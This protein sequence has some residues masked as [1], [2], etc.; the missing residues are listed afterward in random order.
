M[1][2]VVCYVDGFAIAQDALSLFLYLLSHLI[3]SATLWGSLQV[4]EQVGE[5]RSLGSQFSR[6]VKSLYLSQV[7]G[8]KS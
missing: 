3:S 6:V 5:A 8:F 7:I 1:E 2:P 4:R